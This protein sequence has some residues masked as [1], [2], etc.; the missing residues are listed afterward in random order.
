MKRPCNLKTH[1]ESRCCPVHPL[2]N[3]C[4][5]GE[6]QLGTSTGT[7]KRE[8][9]QMQVYKSLGVVTL[10]MT[11]KLKTLQLPSVLPLCVGT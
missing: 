3:Q 2:L 5:H 11:C 8:C 10:G 9:K 4:M 1:H 7:S 6:V